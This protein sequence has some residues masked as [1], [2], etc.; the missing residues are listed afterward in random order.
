MVRFPEGTRDCFYS[1]QCPHSI[2]RPLHLL[3]SRQMETVSFG[4]CSRM[5]L[6]VH[7]RILIT[8][9]KDKF[10][11]HVLLHKFISARSKAITDLS[12]FEACL[13]SI[14]FVAVSFICKQRGWDRPIH[15]KGNRTK[16]RNLKYRNLLFIRT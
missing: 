14:R 16:C 15:Y 12:K 11:F 10:T 2:R 4:G 3:F 6:C 8:K 13:N 7:S 9:N 5:E 1:L